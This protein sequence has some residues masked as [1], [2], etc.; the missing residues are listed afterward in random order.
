MTP[1]ILVTLVLQC[2]TALALLLTLCWMR[3]THFY[4]LATRAYRSGDKA[5]GDA[6][7]RRGHRWSIGLRTSS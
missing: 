6:L 5:A 7:R 1:I 4:N 3:G 2:I